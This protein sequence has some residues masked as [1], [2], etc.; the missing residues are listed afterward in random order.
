LSSGES[1]LV[2]PGSAPPTDDA[3][4]WAAGDGT[5]SFAGDTGIALACQIA[6]FVVT[7]ILA[8]IYARVL[9]AEGKGMLAIFALIPGMVTVMVNLGIDSANSY[10]VAAKRS[11]VELVAGNSVAMVLLLSALCAGVYAML[12]H[13]RTVLFGEMSLPL[14]LISFC[15]VPSMLFTRY[16]YGMLVGLRRVAEAAFTGLISGLVTLLLTLLLVVG[17]RGGL[18]GA[19]TSMAIGSVAGA[20]GG[21][22]LLGGKTWRRLSFRLDVLRQAISFGIRGQWGSVVGFFN[23]R[24]DMFIVNGLVGPAEVGYYSV[25]VTLG[26]LLWYLPS[27]A[28]VSL[29]PRVAAAPS[30]AKHMTLKVVHVLLATLCLAAVLLLLVARPLVDLLFSARFRSSLVPLA[31]LLPGVVLLGISKILNADLV[32]RGKPELGSVA[33]TAALLVTVPGNI[34]LV[35]RYGI[36][37]AAAASTLAYGTLSVLNMLF[38][39]RESGSSLAELLVIRPRE[40]WAMWLLCWRKGSGPLFRALRTCATNTWFAR[41]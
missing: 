37:G 1:G 32:G 28:S 27:A 24:L 40:V 16:M 15:L 10:L 18:Y 34:I 26:E 41:R 9:G 6:G 2:G 7:G 31:L 36:A 14:L 19:V 4:V 38:F 29:L 22:V 39:C 11:P 17:V 12:V 23:Y 30:E 21:A 35:P 13:A 8:V 33:A 25:A 3:P 5:G 20:I